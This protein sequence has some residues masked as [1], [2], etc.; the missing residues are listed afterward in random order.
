MPNYTEKS[1]YRKIYQEHY[2][3][4]PVDESGRTYEIHHID[5]NRNN[6][7]I[8]NL[9]A[10]SIQEHFQIHFNQGDWNACLRI[11]AKMRI[12]HDELRRLAKESATQLVASGRHYWKSPEHSERTRERMRH[13]AS[14]G[15]HAAQKAHNRQASRERALQQRQYYQDNALIP[16]PIDLSPEQKEAKAQKSSISNKI[17]YQARSEESKLLQRQR[18]K[19]AMSKKTEE[20]KRA[21][22]E[23]WRA[24][25]LRNQLNRLQRQG[26]T[27]P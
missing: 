16:P 12:P 25:K 26:S 14:I 19:E 21:D 15:H 18:R 20:E 27:D 11:G 24:S 23:K 3:P 6:N 8:T 13:L 22:I 7:S 2:G 1:D 5:G 9:K 10:V 17:A 4:I